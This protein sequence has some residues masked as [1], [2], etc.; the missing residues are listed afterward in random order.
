MIHRALGTGGL[1]A[2]AGARGGGAVRSWLPPCPSPGG[3]CRPAPWAAGRRHEQPAAPG[4]DPVHWL[5]VLPVRGAA[6]ARETD[7]EQA[8]AAEPPEP[9]A[10]AQARAEAERVLA[11]A[12]AEAASILGAARAEA[13]AE[14]SLARRAGWE[15]GRRQAR[16]EWGQLIGAAAGTLRQ[17]RAARS[18]LLR[19]LRAE[20]ADLA[21]AVAAR[22]LG[23]ELEA[24]PEEV[25]DLA[26]RLVRRVDGP[27]VLRVRPEDAPLLAAEPL[28]PGVRLVPDA[29]LAQGDLRLESAGGVLD[30]TVQG[31]FAQVL[32]AMRGGD[33]D[34]GV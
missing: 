22:V 14:R 6:P 8:L 5:A 25:V 9:D 20:V 27:A 15:E 26:R 30:A 32:G 10:A 12:R 7:D 3:A 1:G 33:G 31:R 17:A 18:A 4:T 34:G 28:P 29:T 24:A 19:S 2:Q 11:L 23:R 13:A 16:A 21:M